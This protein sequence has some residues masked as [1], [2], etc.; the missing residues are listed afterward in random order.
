MIVTP[1]AP[2]VSITEGNRLDSLRKVCVTN[3]NSPFSCVFIHVFV[4]LD[5]VEHPILKNVGCQQIFGFSLI[6]LNVL[7]ML[8]VLEDACCLMNLLYIGT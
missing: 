4:F 2:S 8:V 5:Y 6:A 1:T 3:L 7:E